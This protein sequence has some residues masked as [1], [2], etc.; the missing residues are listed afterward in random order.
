MKSDRSGEK[1]CKGGELEDTVSDG[2]HFPHE[3]GG[4]VTSQSESGKGWVEC[5]RVRMVPIMEKNLGGR[6]TAEL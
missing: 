6:G 5:F 1:Q 4:I 3:V 2:P